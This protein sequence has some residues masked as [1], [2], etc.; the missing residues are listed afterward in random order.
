[1]SCFLTELVKLKVGVFRN[2]ITLWSFVI[3]FYIS[4][5]FWSMSI[6]SSKTTMLYFFHLLPRLF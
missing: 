4:S 1:M 5:E 3:S 2:F 6:Y